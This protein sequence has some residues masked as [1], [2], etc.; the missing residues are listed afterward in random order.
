MDDETAM[1]C[2]APT[3]DLVHAD[4]TSSGIE[5][6]IRIPMIEEV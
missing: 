2:P 4:G 5:V 3:N 1:E 6:L